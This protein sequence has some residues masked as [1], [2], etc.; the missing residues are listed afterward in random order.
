MPEVK[1]LPIIAQREKKC[2]YFFGKIFAFDAPN[3]KP[4]LDRFLRRAAAVPRVLAAASKDGAKTYLCVHCSFP[5]FQSTLL[6]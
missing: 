5:P 6:I 4:K 1:A 2:K 3:G